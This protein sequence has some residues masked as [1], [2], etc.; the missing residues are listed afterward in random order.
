LLQAVARQG[1]AAVIDK[2]K[3]HEVGWSGDSDGGGA[4]GGTTARGFG[5]VLVGGEAQA[6]SLGRTQRCTDRAGATSKKLRTLLLPLACLEL[7]TKSLSDALVATH[8]NPTSASFWAS[9]SSPHT[10]QLIFQ[11]ARSRKVDTP[12]LGTPPVHRTDSNLHRKVENTKQGVRM[13]PEQ[14]EGHTRRE[15]G[16]DAYVCACVRV[17]VC[18]CVRMHRWGRVCVC[19]G[20][21]GLPHRHA[22]EATP[23]CTGCKRA[24]GRTERRPC[25]TWG[26][27]PEGWRP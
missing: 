12:F 23:T 8:R 11:S 25:G 18:A 9:S 15:W 26:S 1:K 6:S 2:L 14:G 21:G 19:V 13:S 4:R 17:C 16:R 27:E 24:E 5:G 3:L 20:G 7:H 22:G 10:G